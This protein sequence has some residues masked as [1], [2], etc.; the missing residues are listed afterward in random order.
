MSN[1]VRCR[2]KPTAASCDCVVFAQ[3][4]S[5]APAAGGTSV[6]TTEYA[7]GVEPAGLCS[8]CLKT[9]AKEESKIICSKAWRIFSLIWF[10]LFCACLVLVAL[11]FILKRSER[12]DLL[13]KIGLYAGLILIAAYA[14]FWIITRTISGK[15]RTERDKLLVARVHNY[16][17]KGKSISCRYVPLCREFY[18]DFKTFNSINQG[19]TKSNAKSV[20]LQ[21]ID[22]NGKAD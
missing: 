8:D 20:Y 5:F 17:M 15:R 21:F 3:N 7:I 1:C 14:I 9:V 16:P 12:I 22:P 4:V 2:E 13:G 6:T 10:P 11:W 18:P 19:I